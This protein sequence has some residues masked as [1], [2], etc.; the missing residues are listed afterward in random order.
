MS[1]LDGFEDVKA[2][3][4]L[5][6]D[7]SGGSVKV[8]YLV[9]GELRRRQLQIGPSGNLTTREIESVQPDQEG[10]PQRVPVSQR[11]AMTDQGSAVQ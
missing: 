8:M 1:T 9:N 7:Q 5:G 2:K 11:W 6:F 10:R 4:I 3:D